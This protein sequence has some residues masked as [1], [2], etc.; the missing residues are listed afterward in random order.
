MSKYVYIQKPAM[1]SDPIKRRFLPLFC[2]QFLGAFND[3]VFKNAL[4]IL[5]AFSTTKTILNPNTLVNLCA[6]L[7]IAPFFLFSGLAGELA[8]KFE[9]SKLI[10]WI[11]LIEVILAAL[12]T[13]GFYLEHT[14]LLLTALFLLGT[15]A[16]FFGPVKYS[17]IP[18]L[19]P[20]SKLV[21]GNGLMGMGTFIAI[22]LGT[23]LGGFLVS[24][25][26]TGLI[27]VSVSICATALMGLLCSFFI[28]N[29]KAYIPKLK[30]KFSPT[31]Q[32]VEI[33]QAVSQNRILLPVII[34]ISWF[35]SYGSIFLTQTGTYTRLVLNGNE[36]VAS[37]ILTV[38]SIGIGLGSL[39]CGKL[40]KKFEMGLVPL[41]AFGLTLFAIDFAFA[42]SPFPENMLNVTT[43]LN[44]S[45]NWRILT[46][47]FLM[48]TFGG[49]FVVPLYTL[50]QNRSIPE[51]RSR[52]IAANNILNAILMTISALISIVLLNIGVS[53]PYLF[54]LTGI[55]NAAV[56]V[57]IFKREP[58][59]LKN[60]PLVQ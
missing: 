15:Q 19:L 26:N 10:R 20:P 52:V 7:F 43:F 57:Y 50:L 2:T 5:F 44:Y 30:V 11:K 16:T 58:D 17:I 49:F 48:G 6:A 4:I 35:W 47:G 45:Q 37:L 33:R 29:A 28:P 42:N 21:A 9:K 24:I 32:I 27:W 22:L 51:Q 13:L 38:F 59:F 34:G 56:A 8:D 18:Q 36:R 41:G 60:K 39:M 53:I 46:D 3:S 40:V 55:L 1:G 23:I 25:P 14:F 54:L 31:Q 12:A